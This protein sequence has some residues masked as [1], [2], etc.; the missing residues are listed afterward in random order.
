MQA[1]ADYLDVVGEVR[2]FL[3]DRMREV[4][5]AGVALDR[6]V[7]DPGIGF[8][9]SAEHNWQL[10]REQDRLLDLGRPVL[11]GWSRKSSLGGLTGRAVDHRV[12]A[13]VAAAL[14]AVQRGAAIVRVHDVAETVD[15]LKVWRAAGL[16]GKDI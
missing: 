9:K 3:A 6:I 12:A 4:S 13:S 11:V 16:T 14:A 10:L 5:A 8:A 7:L 2:E 1:Q 15:A